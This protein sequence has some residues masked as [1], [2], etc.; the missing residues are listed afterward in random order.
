MPTE[1][2]QLTPVEIAEARGIDIHGVLALI[3]AGELAAV[4]WARPGSRR[5]RWRISAEALAAF[6]R[7]RTAQAPAPRER[8]RRQ[9]SE[10][11]VIQFL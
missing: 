4:N 8:R 3:A 11:G 7:R 2:A 5:P 6:E 1:S 9:K 10:A